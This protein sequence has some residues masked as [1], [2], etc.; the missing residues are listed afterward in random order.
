MRHL[1]VGAAEARS[2]RWRPVA[3][4]VAA[5]V[6]GRGSPPAGGVEERRADRTRLEDCG[7]ADKSRWTADVGSWGGS[8]WASSHISGRRRSAV[9]LGSRGMQTA[10]ESTHARSHDEGLAGVAEAAGW[11][12]PVVIEGQYE[13]MDVPEHTGRGATLLWLHG[14]ADDTDQW[15]EVLTDTMPVGM[16]VVCVK[17]PRCGN[18]VSLSCAR[19]VWKLGC[20]L[21]CRTEV[22]CEWGARLWGGAPGVHLLARRLGFGRCAHLGGVGGGGGARAGGVSLAIAT[23]RTWRPWRR[24]STWR[25]ATTVRASAARGSTPRRTR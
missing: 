5:G 9:P 6:W 17:A 11:P 25:E 16:R 22:D 8:G 2:A 21:I 1:C 15:E 18:P 20:N 4:T 3:S 23:T 7:A 12:A 24:G 14:L 10:D 19:C 13:H